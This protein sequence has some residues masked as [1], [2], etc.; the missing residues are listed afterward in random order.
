MVVEQDSAEAIFTTLRV[1]TK[2]CTLFDE[3]EIFEK[4][5]D[6][7]IPCAV[8]HTSDFHSYSVLVL[9]FRK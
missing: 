9:D 1:H 2:D 4:I 8:R 7:F 5:S 6:F 3:L